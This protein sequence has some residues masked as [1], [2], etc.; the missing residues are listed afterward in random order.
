MTDQSP[1]PSPATDHLVTLRDFLRY[2][3]SRFGAAGLA[4][5]HGASTAFDEAAYLVLEGL[6]LP[7]DQLEPF[8]D[9]KL[10]PEERVRLAGLIEARVTT[11]KPSAYLLNRA[12]VQGIPLYVDERVIVPRSFI[13]ELLFSELFGGDDFTLVEDTGSIE[14]VLDLCTGSGAIAIL[15]AEV[16]ENADIDA[17]ELSPEAL[18]VAAIN[19]AERGQGARISL[20]EGDLFGPLEGQTYDLILTNPPYV[21]EVAMDELPAEYRHEPAM[22]LGSGLDGL[23]IVRRILGEAGAHLNPGG[24]LLCEIGAGRE[25]IEAEYPDMPF[26]WLDTEESEGEVFWLP[27]EALGVQPSSTIGAVE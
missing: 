8:L 4:H 11:R 21:D 27:A 23:D 26:L 22:A 15:A 24:G 3:V 2:A 6:K 5:G 25:I 12:Y 7:I 10:L 18:E 20:I 14:S 9:A 19:V 16:F 1:A 13:G 17:V